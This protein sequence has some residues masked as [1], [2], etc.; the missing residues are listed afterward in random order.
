MDFLV[1]LTYFRAELYFFLINLLF[2]VGYFLFEGTSSVKRLYKRLFPE[3]RQIAKDITPPAVKKSSLVAVEES[4]EKISTEEVPDQV[5][6]ITPTLSPEKQLFLAELVKHV[7]TKM[8]R[9][10]FTEARS[11][12]I[13][14]L[15]IDK[16]HKDLNCLL[17]SLYERDK[18]YRKAEFVY[19]DLILVHDMDSEIYMK[20]GFALSIQ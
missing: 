17:A 7:R 3:G 9:G 13:E 15:A 6:E 19:K 8:A 1:S 14:G 20:L 11:K 5:S 2:I 16:W 18:D 4:T 10:E 12:I